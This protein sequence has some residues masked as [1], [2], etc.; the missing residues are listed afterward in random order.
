MYEVTKPTNQKKFTY[1]H[2]T[3]LLTVV[4]IKPLESIIVDQIINH[5]MIDE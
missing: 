5:N 3:D 1:M 2:T 4:Q